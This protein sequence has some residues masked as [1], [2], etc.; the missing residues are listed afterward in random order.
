MSCDYQGYEF[1]APYLDS[2]CI[3]G[4]LWDADSGCPDPT[5]EFGWLYDHGGELPCPCCR[6]KEAVSRIATEA[7][8]DRM[9]VLYERRG[10]PFSK[11]LQNRKWFWNNTR[12]M[13]R[14]HL[15]REGYATA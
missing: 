12:R 4:Y 5:G 11:R 7:I 9:V 6:F 2:V 8:E 10:R 15:I 3:D 13:L 14:A 1:G